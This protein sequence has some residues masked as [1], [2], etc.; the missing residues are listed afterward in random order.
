MNT[1][2]TVIFHKPTGAIIAILSGVYIGNRSSLVPYIG[3]HPIKEVAFFY[4][5]AQIDISLTQDHV[6]QIS[7]GS[8]PVIVSSSGEVKSFTAWLRHRRFQISSASKILCHLEGGMGDQILQAEAITQFYEIFPKAKLTCAVNPAYYDVVK[9]IVGLKN[10]RLAGQL[11]AD[12]NPDFTCNMHTQYI[13]DPRGALYGKASLYGATLGLLSVHRSV[14]LAIPPDTLHAEKDFALRGA[15]ATSPLRVGVHIRSGSGHAKSWNTEPAER[16]ALR[17]I[18]Q[19]KAHAFLFGFNKD[20]Q[21]HHPSA[22]RIDQGYPWIKTAAVIAQLDLLICIDSGPM[23]LARALGTPHL[24]LWGGTSSRDI[25]GREAM[26]HDAR[27]TL[28]CIEQLC[29]SCPQ[30]VPKCMQAHNLDEL[31]ERGKQIVLASR[32]TTVPAN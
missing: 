21:I 11:A 23:H 2:Q 29:Y 24:I 30:G 27:A 32:Q 20:W 10:I 13:S 31:Y 12:F 1:S 16:L 22:T 3:P 17:F 5:P 26:P 7:N 8:P 15:L 25:L 28:P 6:K 4:E 9:N 19:D 18:E 14:T